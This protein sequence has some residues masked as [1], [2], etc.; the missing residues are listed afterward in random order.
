MT[1]LRP[2]EVF[3]KFKFRKQ[4]SNSEM[5]LGGIIP[6]TPQVD[7]GVDLGVDTTR[8]KSTAQS[9]WKSTQVTEP[10]WPGCTVLAV[11]L[12]FGACDEI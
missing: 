5:E 1:Q 8:P 11:G 7:W 12:C 9:T 4:I 10:V 3:R 6:A 2:E